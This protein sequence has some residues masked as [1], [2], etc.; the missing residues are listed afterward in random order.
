MNDSSLFL[1][2]NNQLYD[3]STPIVMGIL[4]VTPDSFYT[5]SRHRTD[6]SLLQQVEQFLNEGAT[7]IDIGGYSTRPQAALVSSEEEINRVCKALEVIRKNF[8]DALL[9]V[10]TFRSPVARIVV[11]QYGVA[12]INDISGGNL[13][14][15]MFET[16]AD[17]GVAYVLM[18]MRGTPQTMQDHTAYEDVMAEVMHFLQKKVAQL[19]MLGVNDVIIDPGFGFAKTIE[20]NY[21]VLNKLAYL[22]EMNV[23][24]LAGL[25][26]KSMIYNLLGTDPKGVLNG[27]TALNML[28]LLGGASIL[29]VHDVKEAAETIQLFEA[30]RKINQVNY[31]K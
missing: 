17:L 27:T 15:L 22:K 30:Y 7:I 28:A 10:D 2:L 5:Q 25:S 11:E 9:S 6:R 14:A 29:R 24:I 12:M 21:E 4:N 18:H 19:H 31:N 16:V 23:P 13:D 20:Q 26:R 8:P 1:K 3:L